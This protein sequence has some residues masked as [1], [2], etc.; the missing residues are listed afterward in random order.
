MATETK[1]LVMS[2]K[3]EAMHA[4]PGGLVP[5]TPSEP[6][7]TD[8]QAR[9]TPRLRTAIDLAY[10]LVLPATAAATI[11]CWVLTGL[12]VL[13]FSWWQLVGISIPLIIWVVG[14]TRA[15]WR[16]RPTP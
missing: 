2:R 1:G 10:L 5:G 6:Y 15:F 16:R 7:M 13:E 12:G 4:P 3:K 11:A 14:T 9:M 8:A